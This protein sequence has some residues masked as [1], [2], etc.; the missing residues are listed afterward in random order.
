MNDFIALLLEKGVT[1]DPTAAIFENM[2]L[3]RPGQPAPELAAVAD[4]LPI[5]VRRGLYNPDMQIPEAEVAAWAATAERQSQMLKK[6]HE[7]G[8][9]L[10]AGSDGM[11]P[12]IVHRELEV[13]AAA[14]IP[15]ADVLRIA[16]LEAARAVGA[17]EETGSIRPGKAADLV[18][19][20]G[21]PLQDIGAVRNSVL[22]MK[23]DTLYRPDELYR[24][25]G[26]EPFR[27]SLDF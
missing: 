25:M 20:E 10:L 6:L 13:Y 5:A 3:H 14:G 11:A 16:T 18:L 27:P 8:V 22:V 7:A 21:D 23:G 26:V 1:I 4:H 17:G 15:N 9:P 19:L 12:F 24:A 2:M